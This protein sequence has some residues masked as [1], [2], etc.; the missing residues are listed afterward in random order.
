[1]ITMQKTLED[2]AISRFSAQH[3]LCAITGASLNPANAH[4]IL[5]N[6]Y[7]K[8]KLYRYNNLMIVNPVVYKAVSELVPTVAKDLLER[9]DLTNDQLKKLNILRSW[10]GLKPV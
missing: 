2:N 7:R 5:I 4:C 6:P 1:M 9:I 8:D 10:R 3:G